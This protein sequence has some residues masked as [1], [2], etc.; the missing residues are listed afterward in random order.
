[1]SSAVNAAQTII[2]QL[3]IVLEQEAPRTVVSAAAAA[4]EANKSAAAIRT[5]VHKPIVM[6]VDGAAHIAVGAPSAGHCLQLLVGQLPRRG[7]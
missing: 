6:T 7:M 2:S 3:I 5:I 1:M 4:I